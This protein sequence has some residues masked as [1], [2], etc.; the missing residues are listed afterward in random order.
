[1]PVIE[2]VDWRLSDLEKDPHEHDSVQSLDFTAFIH[3]VDE[4]YGREVAEW[5]EE[6]AFVTRWFV[7]ENSRR[8]R[9]ETDHQ[10]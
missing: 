8:W 2:N 4:K 1:M 5:A 3:A 7:K 9:F 10:G 6:G